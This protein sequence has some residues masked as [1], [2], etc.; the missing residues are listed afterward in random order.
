MKPNHT[1][2]M[3]VVSTLPYSLIIYL[4]PWMQSKLYITA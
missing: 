1:P 3:H 4:I 2:E